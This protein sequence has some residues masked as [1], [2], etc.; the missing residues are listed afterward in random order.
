MEVIFSLLRSGWLGKFKREK[1]GSHEK[2]SQD[3]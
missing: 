2:L 3:H 1:G